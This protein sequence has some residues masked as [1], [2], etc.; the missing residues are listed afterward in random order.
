MEEVR[1]ENSRLRGKTHEM[2]YFREKSEKQKEE[3]E[4]QAR[5]LKVLER[6]LEES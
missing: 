6:K 2:E 4:E 5:R 1:E 3:N